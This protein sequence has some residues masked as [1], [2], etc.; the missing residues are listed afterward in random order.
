MRNLFNTKALLILLVIVSVACTSQRE[1]DIKAITSLEKELETEGARPDAEK[2]T[3]LLDSY[4]AFVDN[5]KTDTDQR[6]DRPIK[7][8]RTRRRRITH[9]EHRDEDQRQRAE[10]HDVQHRRIEKE[11]RQHRHGGGR[12]GQARRKRQTE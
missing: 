6:H 4:I 5:N 9:S 7:Q 8:V 1:K 2:L 11:I 12:V 10:H 3:K